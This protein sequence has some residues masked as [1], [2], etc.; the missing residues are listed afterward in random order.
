MS[1][2]KLTIYPDSLLREKSERIED[3]DDRIVTLVGDMIDTMHRAK[4]IGL[5]GVQVGV[6]ERLFIAHV[7][8]DMPRVFINPT[9]IETSLGQIDYEEGCL[10]IPT[11][12]ADVTRPA[13]V[14][15]QAWNERGRPFTI[16][17]EGML[18]RVIQH[19]LDHL[20]GI[21]FLD[22]LTEDVRLDVM[23]DYDKS[24]DPATASRG[25]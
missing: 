25:R 8:G 23:A 19:E 20:N 5:A 21:V 14:R 22:H 6:L 2:L 13:A 18:G 16:D 12:Y 17:A 4:G 3:I 9:I 24:V 1:R 7:E 15:I 11:V 10:S